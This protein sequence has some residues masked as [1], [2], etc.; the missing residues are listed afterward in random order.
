MEE[1]EEEMYDD[2]EEFLRQP[3]SRVEEVDEEDEED[4]DEDQI[5]LP[6]IKHE[7]D[8]DEDETFEEETEDEH[9]HEGDEEGEEEEE[10][11]SFEVWAPDLVKNIASAQA[12]K[13]A[14][15][16]RSTTQDLKVSIDIKQDSLVLSSMSLLP[17]MSYRTANRTR[18]MSSSLFYPYS[19]PSPY[20]SPYPHPYFYPYHYHC[21]YVSM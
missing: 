5:V 8:D 12:E 2:E 13:G 11:D 4:D 9:E 6:L 18:R 21:T 14:Q 3:L 19:Y 10:D 1:M 20:P 17:C 7:Y 15:V 16:K